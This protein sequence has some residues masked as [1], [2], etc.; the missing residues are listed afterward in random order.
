MPALNAI[1]PREL[2]AHP[3]LSAFTSSQIKSLTA[4]AAEA[5]FNQG[6]IIFHENDPAD[7]FYLILDGRVEVEALGP[8]HPCPVQTLEAGDEL[9]WSWAVPSSCRFF[10]ARALSP[11][12]TLQFES[13]GLLDLC[14]RDT[15]LGYVFMKSM[16]DVV[17]SRLR[18]AQVQVVRTHGRR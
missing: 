1:D 13:T 18:A 9:G 15:A 4:L 6:E 14:Q 5:N 11:V 16:L 2:A 7:C 8:G 3:F 10:Q 17:S 12:R